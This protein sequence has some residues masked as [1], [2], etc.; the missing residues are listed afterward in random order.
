MLRTLRKHSGSWMIRMILGL[1]VLVFVFWGVGSFRDEQAAAIAHIDGRP[2]AYEDYIRAYN[3]LLEQFSRQIDGNLNDETLRILGIKEQA[4]DQVINQRLLVAE[5]DRLELRVSNDELVQSIHQFPSFQTNGVFDATRYQGVLGSLRMTPEIFEDRQR[6][7]LRIQKLQNFVSSAAQVS[8]LEA[9]EWYQ[10][11]NNEVKIDYFVVAPNKEDA[12]TLSEDEIAAYFKENDAKYKTKPQVKVRYLQFLADDYKDQVNIDDEK[13]TEYYETNTSNYGSPKTVEAR[14]ILIRVDENAAEK[15]VEEARKRLL[16]VLELARAG[17]DFGELA[18]IYSEG[19]TAE[20]GGAL[21]AFKK[22]DMVTPFAATAFNMAVDEVSDPV[23]TR[24]GWHLIKVEKINEA[25]VKIL[26]EVKETIAGTLTREQARVMA[27]DAAEAVYENVFPGDDLETLGGEQNVKVLTTDFFDATGPVTL[28]SGRTK[29]AQDA[30]A[31]NPGDISDLLNLGDNY[32]LFQVIEKKE[33]AIPKLEAVKEKVEADLLKTK[34]DEKAAADAE[35]ILAGVGGAVL[36]EAAVKEKGLEMKTT[37]FF[38]RNDAIPA[39]GRLP[40]M[41]EAAFSLTA[42]KSVA[43]KPIKGPGGY[44]GFQ[45]NDFRPADDEG[46]T[47]KKDA[48]QAQLIQQK[49]GRRI[50]ALVEQLRDKS[51]IEINQQLLE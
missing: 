21:G 11:Q 44:Y 49:R 31:L 19:P 16:P 7:S 40:E 9:R 27:A 20:R 45:L 46:F 37:E 48:I 47:E 32:Y 35:A 14:H 42:D 41:T 15:V 5:A 28:P 23:R 12:I 18:K 13:I 1:I 30:L 50:S 22:E 25:T 38:K 3:N 24:F 43:K 39:I 36:F 51:T 17:E 34:R 29:F 4:L 26:E 10:W 8:E 2:V 6:Q 33:A